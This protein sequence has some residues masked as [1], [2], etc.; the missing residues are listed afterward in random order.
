M[1]ALGGAISLPTA[2][3]DASYLESSNGDDSEERDVTVAN[4]GGLGL[5]YHYYPWE[6]SAFFLGGAASWESSKVKFEERT[7]E[8]TA[9]S[10][11]CVEVGF[12]KKSLRIGAVV[13][14]FW[15][16]EN[17]F[18]LLLDLG[19]RIRVQHYRS[20]TDNGESDNVDQSRRDDFV[21][22]INGLSVFLGGIPSRML[23]YSF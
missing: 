10:K 12:R 7:R 22:Q 15:I 1:A 18:S 20:F 3:I 9:T 5:F 6:T 8:Y 17:G 4:L 14:W 2:D 16:W 19:P 11:E 13:G 21:D 23:G